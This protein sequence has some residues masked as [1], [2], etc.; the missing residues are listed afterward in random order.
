[1][2]KHAKYPLRPDLLLM[3]HL[4]L[5]AALPL[6]ARATPV[7]PP[8]LPYI[9]RVEFGEAA[10]DTCPP[11]PCPGDSLRVTIHGELPGCVDFR[12]LR[13]VWVRDLKGPYL[14]A[15][16]VADTCGRPCIAGFTP[17]SASTVLPPATPGTHEVS[18][19]SQVRTCP[20]TTLIASAE[21]REFRFLVPPSCASSPLDSL[22]QSFVKF[23]V[24]P[25]PRCAE[26]DLRLWIGENVCPPCV[27]IVSFTADPAPHA[28]LEWTPNCY[29]FYCDS[30]TL[31]L[32]IGRF[33]AGS[34]V[35][36]ADVDVRVLAPGVVDSVLSFQAAVPFEVSA[37][38][39]TAVACVS[40]ELR[41]LS[42]VPAIAVRCDVRV[43]PGGHG[44]LTLHSQSDLPLGGLQ[45]K[46]HCPPPFRVTGL[47]APPES[48]GLHVSWVPEGR[49]A[50]YVLFTTGGTPIPAGMAPVLAV[51]L[52]CDS[53][54]TVGTRVALGAAVEV[55]S[56]PGGEALPLCPPSP[57]PSAATWM[58]VSDVRPTCDVNADGQADVRDLVLMTTCLSLDQPV[59]SEHCRDCDRDGTWSFADL[60][61]CANQVL[62]LPF[63]PRD[64]VNADGIRVSFDDVT[65]DGEELALRVRLSG[66]RDLGAALLRLR[67]PGERWR[68]DPPQVVERPGATNAGW[69]PL[70]D[71]S[72]SGVV[73]LGGLRLTTTAADAI[74]FVL[75]F[76]PT[77]APNAGDRLVVEGADLAGVDGT[78]FTL[79]S[80]PSLALAGQEPPV[81]PRVELG[82]A[83]PNPFTDVTTFALNLPEE[84]DVDLAIHDL[85]GRHVATLFHGRLPAGRRDVAWRAEEARAGMYFA[86]LVVNGQVHLRRVVLVRGPR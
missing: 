31:S 75:R 83:R 76:T 33:A 49:G 26:D 45:G 34:H 29:E 50:R 77:A 57:F 37:T 84:A 35:I 3:F 64:S 23:K 85:A 44:S 14:L 8:G 72:Q 70:A 17:Y 42:F 59:P 40:P 39:D 63:P 12:G 53:S 65:R 22:V 6:A 10:C 9:H 52:L 78:A 27:R 36:V 56:G 1:M 54:A 71:P 15:D 43:A 20:D 7:E 60:V 30:D 74:E 11:R 73:Q 19:V 68:V 66:V 18:I 86:R 61:C 48:F 51:T 5:A 28:T 16:F 67:Y 32:P 47:S 2:S 80:K 46:L 4:L 38:C 62:Q 82:P 81:G 58:C 41:A 55:A 69:M 21:R 24:L 79:A 25:E 13:Q